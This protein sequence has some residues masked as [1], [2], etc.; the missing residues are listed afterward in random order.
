MNIKIAV[1]TGELSNLE[2]A[3]TEDLASLSSHLED[4][5]NSWGHNVG[6]RS[7]TNFPNNETEFLKRIGAAS[8]DTR[9]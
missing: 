8:V 5:S 7:T 1:M 2:F 4:A 6:A 3:W 9:A